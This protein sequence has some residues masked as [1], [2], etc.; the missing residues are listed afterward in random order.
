MKKIIAPLIIT[1][2]TGLLFCG[3]FITIILA[4]V[5]QTRNLGMLSFVLIIVL[6]GLLFALIHNLVERI[7]EIKEEDEDDLSKY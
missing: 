7:K 5:Q 2:I 4:L 6:A 1:I 3:Y